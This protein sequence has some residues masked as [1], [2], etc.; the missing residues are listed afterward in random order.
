MDRTELR[1]DPLRNVIPLKESIAGRT[2]QILLV[3][4]QGSFLSTSL[5]HRKNTDS[6]HTY[7]L[8]ILT[9]AKCKQANS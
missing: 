2:A 8:T 4:G 1:R 5:N 7:S 3:Y 9:H 6:F